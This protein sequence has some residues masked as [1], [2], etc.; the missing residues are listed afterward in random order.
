MKVQILV[1][2]DV[3]SDVNHLD[4]HEIAKLGD[5]SDARLKLSAIQAVRNALIGQE[6]D[7]FNHELEEVSSI[8]V[9]DVELHGA[10]HG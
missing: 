10:T 7:G 3:T 5:I 9:I 6:Q 1:T 8:D 4:P 2:L